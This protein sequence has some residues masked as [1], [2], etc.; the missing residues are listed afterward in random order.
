MGGLN[1][2]CGT[3]NFVYYLKRFY[4]VGMIRSITLVYHSTVAMLHLVLWMSAAAIYLG[5]ADDDDL[6]QEKAVTDSVDHTKER[7]LP[8]GRKVENK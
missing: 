7:R 5:Y 3:G 1:L 8:R 2:I 4:R 6:S